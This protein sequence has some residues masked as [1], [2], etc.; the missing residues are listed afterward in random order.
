MILRLQTIYHELRICL[1]HITSQKSLT[2]P[3]G[4]STFSTLIRE[5]PFDIVKLSSI[6]YNLLFLKQHFG[7]FASYFLFKSSKP[8]GERVV[9][10]YPAVF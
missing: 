9:Y 4:K 10:D 3:Y 6:Q 8:T 5:E 7:Y 1:I 2:L